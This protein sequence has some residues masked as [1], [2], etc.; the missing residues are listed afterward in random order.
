[1]AKNRFDYQ[2]QL[3]RHSHDTSSGY[4]SS[5]CPGAIVPQY[6]DILGPGDSVYYRTHMFGRLQDVVTA[7]LGEVDLHIDYFFVPLQML[8]TPFGQIFA[9]T[10]DL[11]SSMFSRDRHY[12]SIGDTFPL[13]SQPDSFRPTNYYVG[14]S[15][16][17]PWEVDGKSVA[18]LLDSLNHNP[19]VVFNDDYWN[20]TQHE[21]STTDIDQDDC[22]WPNSSPWLFAAYQA[23]YQKYYRNDEFESLS[24]SAYNFDFVFDQTS[25]FNWEM[26]QMRWH[27]RYSDYF[28]NVHVS[29]IASSV[30]SLGQLSSSSF[31]VNGDSVNSLL[32]KVDSFLN[33]AGGGIV[34][35]SNT[36]PL[37]T[38]NNSFG[39][40]SL[41][42]RLAHDPNNVMDYLSTGNIRAL[43]AV[44][45]FSRIYG[46]A[47]KTYDD[48]ILAHFGIHIPHDVKH[49]LTH[50]KHYK[51]VIQADPIFGTANTFSP[52]DALVSTIG[53][54]GGQGQ[55][56][57]DTDQEKFTAPVHGVFMAVAYLLTKP[58]Y[59]STFSKLHLLSDRLSFPIP[60]FDKL[61]V[62][63]L[64]AFEV[65]RYYNTDSKRSYRIG[66]QRRWQQFKEQ[67]DRASFTFENHSNGYLDEQSN[68]WSPW[69]L[70]RP[71]FGPD[72][73]GLL[74]SSTSTL[75]PAYLLFESP[76]S[77]D[78]VMVVH[79]DGS[80]HDSW[81]RNPHLMFQTDPLIT[82]FKCF[83]KKVSW[84][85]ETGEPDL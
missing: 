12:P 6:F 73:D 7:F 33:P 23:I 39:N 35:Q 59:T 37:Y 46:R 11:I 65:N 82:E 66:W 50:L 58:R 4:T 34:F 81:Y 9:Q 55:G 10:D 3:S 67:Y 70:A 78:N 79:Y 47:D 31:P 52:D 44:D 42:S 84:M 48:Q 16:I 72:G 13:L 26:I 45:K 43:F 32:T 49:D 1:M 51:V 85:S 56:S 57:I 54:V 61:G 15:N 21:Q 64:Y 30:N 77:L 71:A 41:Y 24:V 18:R 27:Q 40:V 69:V 5:L 74:G 60:E 38:A 8:Y 36:S 2:A 83:C 19:F 63:P 75:V 20:D 80:W 25:F 17:Y 62:Q 29:P 76:H 28:T 68:A 22:Q 53:Q 14:N